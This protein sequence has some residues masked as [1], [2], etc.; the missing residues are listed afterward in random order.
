MCAFYASSPGL[1]PEKWQRGTWN[2]EIAQGLH[3]RMGRVPHAG[4]GTRPD[5]DGRAHTLARQRVAACAVTPGTRRRAV[6]R[7]CSDS[8][9]GAAPCCRLCSCPTLCSTLPDAALSSLALDTGCCAP[10]STSRTI[11]IVLVSQT[12]LG[13]IPQ[14]FSVTVGVCANTFLPLSSGT[15][16]SPD[17]KI[18]K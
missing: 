15:Y 13:S 1:G 2:C 6:A 17:L 12:C 5:G 7:Q 16:G 10:V 4:A 8:D 18:Q 11:R 14:I 9:L 3:A